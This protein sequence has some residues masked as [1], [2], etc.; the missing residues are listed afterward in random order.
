MKVFVSSTYV[1]L[2]EHRRAVCDILLRLKLQPVAMEFFGAEPTDPTSVCSQE[3]RDCDIFV[4]IYAHRYGY[5]L[6]DKQKSITEHEFD[7]ARNLGK[8]CFCYLVEPTYPWRPPFIE[9]EPGASKLEAFKDRVEKVLLRDRFTYPGDLASK[10]SADLGQ[11]LAEQS[12]AAVDHAARLLENEYVRISKDLL[13]VREELAQFQTKQREVE[14]NWAR[15]RDEAEQRAEGLQRKLEE[16]GRSL[17]GEVPEVSITTLDRLSVEVVNVLKAAGRV[18][19]SRDQITDRL[20]EIVYEQPGEVD[21]RIVAMCIDGTVTPEDVAAAALRVEAQRFVGAR[22]VTRQRL[23]TEVFDACARYPSVKALTQGGFYASL[24]ALRPYTAWLENSY[25]FEPVNP[26]D[27]HAHKRASDIS[28]YYVDPPYAVETVRGNGDIVQESRNGRLD[29]YVDRWLGEPGRNHVSVLGEF[30]AGKTWFCRRY[31]YDRLRAWQDDP[32]SQRLPVLINLREYAKHLDV[33]SMILAWLD[34]RGVALPGGYRLFEELNRQGRLLLIFDGFDEMARKVDYQTVVDNFWRLA[35]VVVPNSRILLTCRS[36]YFRHTREARRVLAG[37]EL[38]RE[39]ISLADRPRFDVVYL[40]PF[41]ES[42]ILAVLTKRLAG[43]ETK[44]KDYWMQIRKTPDFAELGKRPVWLE[45][46]LETLPD[47]SPGESVDRAKLYR[48]W[49]NR[50]LDQMAT[51]GRV[52][53]DKWDRLFFLSELAWEMWGDPERPQPRIHYKEFPSRIHARFAH[54]IKGPAELDYFDYD[55]RTQS[56]LR[57]DAE[58]NF[59]FDRKSLAEFFIAFKLALEL[60]AAKPAY[61]DVIPAGELPRPKTLAELRNTFGLV[62]LSR[63]VRDFLRYIVGDARA[64]ENVIKETTGSSADEAGYS[65]G[66]AAT[67]LGLLQ[68][69]LADLPLAKT[70][71]MG[72]A[73]EDT[74]LTLVDLRE[75]NLNRAELRNVVLWQAKMSGS[76][77]NDAELDNVE[78]TEAKMEGVRMIKALIVGGSL[79]GA[80]LTGAVLRDAQLLGVTL[81]ATRLQ[82]ADLQGTVFEQLAE[83]TNADFTGA[84]GLTEETRAMLGK[85]GAKPFATDFPAPQIEPEEE[86]EEALEEVG[87]ARDE[88]EPSE[89]L[90]DASLGERTEWPADDLFNRARQEAP[91]YRPHRGSARTFMKVHDMF[92]GLIQ[93]AGAEEDDFTDLGDPRGMTVI[94]VATGAEIES[95]LEPSILM[96]SG[97]VSAKWAKKK[98]LVRN[99][100]FQLRRKLERVRRWARRVEG[101]WLPGVWYKN[102]RGDIKA[103]TRLY[104]EFLNEE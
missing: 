52:L 60:G 62:P 59:E 50:R 40:E 25:L 1:D 8:P 85:R 51:Q 81:T 47:I 71:L 49:T 94:D 101:C 17:P 86:D 79:E 103:H 98:E 41:D 7:L 35:E 37:E 3:I 70:V 39:V 11:W 104:D 54:R 36:E 61:T 82:Q 19:R 56:F 90:E 93:I 99:A 46:I 42:R 24:I 53:V 80:D 2:R 4:G 69:S 64:L 73:L 72:L 28:R 48:I 14:A 58:G 33:R 75:T 55:L 10:V 63:E 13:L 18:I 26:A 20:V 68:V 32:N 74:D 29:D 27:P 67:L 34:Q 77:L 45:M 84:K 100:N 30:G 102:S 88:V 23:A 95:Q 57:R 22:I 12:P 76:H 97:L 65:G 87:G 9:Q 5:V 38:G 66:N 92:P 44:A 31:A 21:V 78:F 43:D 15:Q 91:H 83:C 96:P 89:R 16:L 6:E